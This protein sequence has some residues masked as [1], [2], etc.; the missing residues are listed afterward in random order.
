MIFDYIASDCNNLVLGDINSD[1]IK[2][3]IVGT[4]YII[5][6]FRERKKL[7]ERKIEYFVEPSSR[8]HTDEEKLFGPGESRVRN[9]ISKISVISKDNHY[10]I[11]VV[12]VGGASF[13]LDAKDGKI[14]QKHII[15]SSI[16][17]VAIGDINNDNVDEAFIAAED[18]NIYEII[19]M[20][21]LRRFHRVEEGKPISIGLGDVNG[22]KEFEVV[23]GTENGRILVLNRNGKKILEE[24]LSGA[25]IKYIRTGDINNDNI[26]EIIY[27]TSDGEIGVFFVNKRDFKTLHKFEGE[28]MVLSLLD[29]D[30]DSLQEVLGCD[31]YGSFLI[32]DAKKDSKELSTLTRK[33][34]VDLDRDGFLENVEIHSKSIVVKKKDVIVRKYDM[35]HWISSAV[36]TDIDRDGLKEILIGSFDKSIWVYS[37]REK[38]PTHRILLTGVPIAISCSDFDK[39]GNTELLVFTTDGVTQLRVLK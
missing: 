7:W 30:N 4:S 2:E 15:G 37:L 20:K 14:I 36:I 17:D 11:M 39:D 25:E 35:R 28:I 29:I 38:E 22:D 34:E 33:F 32:Y 1:D 8:S 31:Y 3:L 6:C 12:V 27:G 19:K 9:I 21:K 24:R 16:R 13:I 10:F 5:K 18:G 23:V 26:D